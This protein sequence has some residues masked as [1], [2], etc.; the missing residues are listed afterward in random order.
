MSPSGYPPL[1]RRPRPCW[2]FSVTTSCSVLLRQAVG[3]P[4]L[5]W[6]GVIGQHTLDAVAAL[7]PNGVERRRSAISVRL[8]SYVKT[9]KTC[10]TFGHGWKARLDAVQ[11][12]A[13]T[14]ADGAHAIRDV[15]VGI[16][17]RRMRPGSKRDKRDR[18]R[19]APV[20]L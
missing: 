7:T 18:K 11:V 12:E 20:C 14:M 13:L 15:R 3:F 16:G 1:H 19:D 8:V 4:L 2:S 6:D 9:L 5:K 10:G 17:R